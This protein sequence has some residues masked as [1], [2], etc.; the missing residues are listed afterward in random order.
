M[1]AWVG[2]SERGCG[3]TE[4]RVRVD[5]PAH[6]RSEVVG[7]NGDV[8]LGEWLGRMRWWL[9]VYVSYA[10]PL[11]YPIPLPPL[12]AVLLMSQTGQRE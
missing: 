3:L 2:V 1:C 7:R 11:Q 10:S 6:D 5:V 4:A 8:W 12:C 9:R